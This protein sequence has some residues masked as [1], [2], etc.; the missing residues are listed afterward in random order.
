MDNVKLAVHATN[1]TD[2]ISRVTIL[3]NQ[4][5]DMRGRVTVVT[6][7]LLGSTVPV[8]ERVPVQEPTPEYGSAQ[9]LTLE[10]DELFQLATEL[11][12]SIE[13]LVQYLEPTP[14]IAAAPI[15]PSQAMPGP[16]ARPAGHPAQKIG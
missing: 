11:Q 7:Q 10:L 14:Q 8:E 1:N 2:A 3:Q 15:A 16:A 12:D 9:R 6:T 13:H 4:L 5:A